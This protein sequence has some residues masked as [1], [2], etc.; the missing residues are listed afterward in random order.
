MT[1]QTAFPDFVLD[2][3]IPEGFK[4]ISYIND[5]CPSWRNDDL[6]LDLF[7]D[8]ADAALRE[9]ADKARFALCNFDHNQPSDWFFTDVWAEVLQEIERR[10]IPN[11][12][13]VREIGNG[14]EI[15]SYLHCGQCLTEWKEGL[16]PG[17]SPKTY[18]RLSVGFTA[19]GLQVWCARHDCNV[20]NIDFEGAVHPA[21]VTAKLP[22]L[23]D[24][25][26]VN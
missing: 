21:N 23:P 22:P 2:V 18:A 11:T 17:E 6:R 25:E 3:E 19:T 8:Y 10:K 5:T 24:P 26:S 15:M 13:P 1:Y 20:A 9:T 14:L 16:A 4:D 12:K 7:I